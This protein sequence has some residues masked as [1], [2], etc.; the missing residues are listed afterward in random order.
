MIYAARSKLKKISRTISGV[1]PVAVMAKPFPCPGKCVYC[2]TS[3]EAPKSYTVE[4]PAVLR[5]RKCDF[6]A[7]K[8]VEL[9]LATLT[10]MGHPVDKVELIVMGGTFL[11]YHRE[12]QYEFIKGCYD[13]LNG[14]SSV[15]LE[16]A[17]RLNETAKHRCTGLCIE[18][19]P[20]FCG[21]EEIRRMLDF[22]TTR[23]EIGVQ[24]LDDEIHQV[25]KRGHG[26]AEVITATRLLRDYGF[27]VYYHWMPGL[28]GSTPDHDLELT[29]RLFEEECFRPDGLKLYPTLVVVGS[30]LE[31]WYQLGRYQPYPD[32]EMISLLANMKSLIPKYVRISR[33]MRDI[34]RKFIVAG[35]NDLA[36]RET[37][38]R[39]MGELG[40]R[41]YCI[42]CREY[43]H[44]LK[45][46]WVMD[47]PS[48]TRMDYETWGGKEIFLSYED[49]NET[50]FGLLRLRINKPSC[51]SPDKGYWDEGHSFN[52]SPL[53]GERGVR[54]RE[55]HVF[56]PEVPLGE[57]QEQA[58]Q[59]RG[60]GAILLHEAERIAKEEPHDSKLHILSGVGARDYYRSL[61]YR[62][63][64][65]YM[66]KEF[67]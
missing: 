20:D 17:K 10:D 58:A 53:K 45:D 22:G 12:Y 1:T 29:R 60:L 59:H 55:L 43:G 24:T 15:N 64:G 2:P 6:E 40:M 31:N 7:W 65:D 11:A 41:C 30:E 9:R 47:Q 8:Q 14:I 25:T 34:P 48:L 51:P 49:V 37:V 21:E 50:L 5:A 57:K 35:S 38:R 28:P 46:G 36:L 32:E 54:V 42:R 67:A 44:R 27:K 26:V 52:L 63:E 33:L 61:G 16:E 56:G 62:L 39:R 4:S 66:V 13:A 19:R 3:P 18:T 23:V